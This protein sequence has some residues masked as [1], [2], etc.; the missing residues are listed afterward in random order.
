MLK[1]IAIIGSSGALGH[2]FTTQIALSNPD[3]EIH[4]FTSKEEHAEIKNVT[5]HTL[6]YSSESAI[7][8]AALLVS[9]DG[10][11]GLVIIATGILH[12]GDL[13]PEKSLKSLSAEKMQYLFAVNTILPSLVAKHFS[14]LLDR[15]NKSLFAVLSARAGSISDNQFGGWYSYRASKAALNMIIKNLS[16]EVRRRNKKAIIVGLHPGTVD[17]QLTKPYQKNV[18]EGQLFTADYS[19]SALLNVLFDLTTKNSGNFFA[20]DGEEIAP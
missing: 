5:T 3:A 17:S 6:D 8:S 16:I 2:A 20:W 4:A 18:P 9:K 11:L 15:D 12:E 7:E 14:P 13:L 10:P 1:N 19:A